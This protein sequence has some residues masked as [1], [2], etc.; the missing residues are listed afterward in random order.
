MAGSATDRASITRPIARVAVDQPLAH[1]DRFFDYLV[2]EAMDAEAVP[3]AR[4]RVRFAGRLLDG[5]IVER[6]SSTEV[7]GRLSPLEKVIS[8]EPV[9]TSAQVTL[10]RAV[11]DH[12]AG[13]FSDVARLA[14]PPRHATTEKANQ[15]EWARPSPGD[16][17]GPL[18]SYPQ[19]A[20]FLDALRRGESPRAFWQVVPVSGGVGDWSAGVAEAVAATV[21]SGRGAIVL[22]PDTKDLDRA[23]LALEQ[24]LGSGTVAVLHADLGAA[25]R[26]RNYLALSRGQASVVV[27]TRPAAYAPVANL[28]LVV[29]WDDGDDLFAEQRAPYPHARDVAA[30]RAPLEGCALLLAAHGRSCEVQTWLERGWLAPIEF[31][32]AEARRMAPPVRGVADSDKALERDPLAR[33][34]RL[35]QA[36]FDVLRVGLAQGPVLV[37]VPRF[38]YLVALACDRCRAP[39]R[40]STC[41]G[42]LRA[43]RDQAGRHLTCGWCAR[44]TTD[45]RCATCGGARFRAPVVGST[46][47]GEELGRAFPGTLVI[48]SSGDRVVQTVDDTPTIVVATP[49]GEP[50]APGGYAAALLLDA[51]MSLSRP[52]LRTSEE[53]L[54]RWLNAT[55]L[56]RPGSEGGTVCVVGPTDDRTIQALIRLDPAGAAA[57][58]L[59][60]RRD[61]HLPPASRFAFIEGRTSALDELLAA[62]RLG[63][64]AR[65]LGPVEL[66][67]NA[68]GDVDS[69]LTISA[70]LAHGRELA[71][72]L[73]QAAGVRSARKDAGPLRI[74]LDPQAIG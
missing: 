52:D 28:G 4:V 64:W 39:A 50:I 22:V 61:A 54:R 37:Q 26:Y 2:P 31:T 34:V 40:C 30:L 5:F 48:D 23:R 63:D 15:R 14:V 55:A 73:R 58:E 43:L 20:G 11:A 53:A 44:L 62:A 27:G 69:R 60:D 47:T 65:V 42:P 35:P 49:G 19:G 71:E 10:I 70:D 1:L 17:A 16:A 13:S 67:P 46:R 72:A 18:S 33:A 38:G 41:H 6:A 24:R 32:A 21:A 36:A 8:S 29:V 25:T 57:R 56:V 3:G 68:L 66:P 59:A 9:L 7:A 51:S 45:W 12:Y 74:R